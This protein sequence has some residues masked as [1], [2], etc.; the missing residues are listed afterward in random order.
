MDE[1]AAVTRRIL[2]TGAQGFLG[3]YLVAHLLGAE[4]GSEV[5]G[6]GRSPR[7]EDSFTHSLQWGAS[8]LEAPLP[9]ELR[10][11]L[12][13]PRYHYMS[14]DLLRQPELTGL[15]MDFRPH[16]IF[17][18][19]SGLRDAAPDHLFR[20][21][22]EG[23]ISLIEAIREAGIEPPRLV[24]GSTGF[25][26]GQVEPDVLPIRESTPCT[27][28]DLYGVSKLAA[29]NAARILA[30]RYDLPA[31]WAR[32]FN[33]VGPGQEERHFCGR[34]TSQAAAIAAGLLPPLVE[35]EPLTA[36]RD[37]LDVRDAASALD[38]LAAHGTPGHIYNVA[39][40]VESPV[41]QVFD[42][43]LRHAGLEGRVEIDL[44]AARP[45]DI[46]RYVADITRLRSLGFAPACPLER[47]LADLLHYY[48]GP[49]TDAASRRLRPPHRATVRA[50]VEADSAHR[51]EVEVQAGLLEHL[52]GR[53]R[54]LYPSAQMV[55][56][57]DPRVLALYGTRLVEA[58]RAMGVEA[59]VALLPEGER[60]KSP[61]RYL[62]L[63]EQLHAL[64]FDRRALL[65]NLGGGILCDVGG[66][67]A[68]TYM[69][70]V[71]YVNV[72]TT[73][74]AQ[75]DAGIGGKVAVNMP[76][77]KNF[78]GA[79]AHP[80][81]VF[82]D[83][84]VLATLSG[85]ELSA[86]VAE[87]IKVAIIG[88]PELFELLETE[89]AAIRSG[90][91]ARV[92]GEVVGRASELKI[93]MLAPDPY[94]RNLRRVLN[95][96]H[97]FGHALEVQTGYDRLL[98]GEAV[99]FGLAVAAAV[100]RRR[101]CCS[102]NT[103]ERIFGCLNAYGLPPRVA[104]SDLLAACGRLEEIRLVR[105]RSLNFVLPTEI[106]GV[107]IVAELSD[108]EIERA[109]ED[110]AAHPTLGQSV[111][112]DACGHSDSISAAANS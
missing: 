42:S 81:A 66:F 4:P 69:R 17:H 41:A 98:H 39:S 105:G 83:P 65:V 24:L 1:R 5:L 46:P 109:L 93:A 92:L 77:A 61:E 47:S 32:I 87:A 64:H 12:R 16:R 88:S 34:L 97:T 48:H 27:P 110:I 23:T 6:L 38:L 76:W 52:P 25:L 72:P 50:A 28:I 90:K 67:L 94:E 85:R 22:V 33:L 100:A 19:A 10:G 51:Y 43:I 70:G 91:D 45:A 14:L 8:R 20:T 58:L 108:G 112:E 106:G 57:T 54:G 18:L 15:L 3:R 7:L 86:G 11:A 99:G 35:V 78:V 31:I 36:T 75:L 89:S 73:L 82:C 13:S 80:K 44:K 74:L 29:E 111:G 103:L 68:A 37:F 95:L 104:R 60:S 79:F 30:R 9:E 40:G 21:N 101:G 53:L 107:E 71:A 62:E 96:G 56:L 84:V 2:V 49:V 102:R 59:G 26:Y 55:I 63:I